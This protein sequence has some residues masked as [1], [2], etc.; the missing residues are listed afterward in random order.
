MSQKI[1]PRVRV[2]T[3][4]WTRSIQIP[5]SPVKFRASAYEAAGNGPRSS[6]WK[7]AG[8]IGPVSLLGKS[9]DTLRNRVRYQIR[10]DPIASRV[11]D[12]LV[13]KVIGSGLRPMLR[14]GL[15]DP[16]FDRVMEDWMDQCDAEG[17]ASFDGIQEIIFRD[18]VAGGDSIARFRPRD[19]EEDAELTIP[20]QIQVLPGE[21]MPSHDPSGESVS[22][23]IRDGIG[24]IRKYKIFKKHPGERLLGS[25]ELG[26]SYIDA[27][28]V[29]HV[30]WKRE[31]GQVRGE[32][33]LTRGLLTL[34]DLDSYQDAELVRKKLAAMPVFFIQTPT[35]MSKP[36]AP[37]GISDGE[38][39]HE[40]GT[41][42]NADGTVWSDE[43]PVELM[44]ELSPGGVVPVAP[45]HEVKPSLP[46]DVGPNY[47][48]FVR[49]Q[50]QRVCSA[51]NSP[52]ELVTGDTPPGAN[53]RMMRIRLNDFY[54]LVKVWRRMMVRQ[55]CQPA[56]RAA[57][58]A[59]YDSGVWEPKEGTTLK[60]YMT[61]DWVGDPMP[62]VNPEQE[63]RADVIAVRAGFKTQ[64]QVIRERGGDPDTLFQARSNEVKKADSLG[65]M[66]DS[67]PRSVSDAGVTQSRQGEFIERDDSGDGDPD[68]KIPL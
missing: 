49:R 3:D 46:A 62:L 67:D 6:S 5:E 52:Y 41:P 36:N 13:G 55:F 45:G 37:V 23:V 22:G 30:F 43:D 18:A 2:T 33:W 15:E 17:T 59:A 21:M 11:V 63:V 54:T 53:E 7:Q 14:P 48:V 24:R 65:I 1:K 26:H 32:P 27:K 10:N 8:L 28:D 12:F 50:L 61:V 9:L 29:A 47:D 57:V 60:D 44:P 31:P 40:E 56:W 16:E 34:H 58:Q 39:G 51:V 4:G 42:L 64:S 19:I 38:D 66:F 68:E 25:A 35:D 20:M